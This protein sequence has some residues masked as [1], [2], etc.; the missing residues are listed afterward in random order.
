MSGSGT[1]VQANLGRGDF[2]VR[3][4][5]IA[6]LTV[7]YRFAFF[8]LHGL[9]GSAAFLLGLSICLLAA[10][11]LGLRGAL[12]AV[13]VV[14]VIDQGFA[15]TLSGPGM[16]A[17]AGVIALLIKLL[18]A[19]G[20]CM[21]LDSRRRFSAL[22]IELGEEVEARK[23]SEASLRHAAEL[24]RALVESLG[25]GV[26]VC[27]ADGRVVFANPALS[28]ALG[29]PRDELLG[30]RF[31]QWLD[32]AA[33]QALAPAAAGPG[34]A[35]S[36]EA[37]LRSDPARLLLVTQTELE[38]GAE[39][40]ALTLSVVRD[41]TERVA[42][43]RRQRELE[44]ELQRSEALR[45]LAVLAG[46]VAHDFNNLLCGVVGNAEVV[47]RR[48]PADAPE[49]LSR[50][51]SEIITFAGEAAH[52]AKQMLAY[53]GQRSLGVQALEPHV[54]LAAA[55]RL[56][57]ATIEPRARLVLELDEGL[58]EI[59]AD[60]FQ[61]RQVITNL[62][63]NAL[64][65][66]QGERGILT[67]RIRAVQL[68]AERASTHRL[69]PGHYVTIS[70]EDDGAGILPEARERLFEPFFSTKGTGRGMGLAAAA[71]ILRAHRGWLGVEATSEQG[72]RFGSFWPVARET[73][74]RQISV[75]A[76]AAVASRPRSV[77]LI[78]DEP[79]VRVVTA[80]L[81]R[82][83]G[84]Q[85]VTAESG[86]RAL[87]LFREQHDGIDLIVLDLTLPERSGEQILDDL[88]QVRKDVPVVITSGF[89]AAD[90][91]QILSRPNVIGFLEKPHTLSSLE[92][93]VASAR[94][95]AAPAPGAA[96]AGGALSDGRVVAG[97]GRVLA[98]RARA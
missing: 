8:P 30:Q 75:P 84:H 51:L 98:G 70:V 91:S 32:D 76:A 34:Q 56:L 5:G 90:A 54:E 6:S 21:V 45:S 83:L 29:V 95:D 23:R 71:G 16:G 36:F 42:S 41:L 44:R 68:D 10:A 65:A 13:A 57:R 11:L 60:R 24:H 27:D 63:L 20:L 74:P 92:T 25:E 80:R 67:L 48:L 82:E 96:A 78:D 22:S 9:I 79:A 38:P 72:T 61:L 59:A 64:E 86:R 17:A 37:G 94:L 19:V 35:R 7:V 47:K 55:L 69:A 49:V 66:M 46:G 81:L 40:G 77:L 26:G 88:M 43:E 4:L 93:I 39:R 73:T 87:E 85:V 15:L 28:L 1:A 53:G 3:W 18:L 14:A 31:L 33:P 12:V 89:Q 58:P 62:V 50:C 97:R 52:L 2:A